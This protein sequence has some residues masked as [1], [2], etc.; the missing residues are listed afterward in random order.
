[1]RAQE[2]WF[3]V[4]RVGGEWW[5]FN[6]L[7]QAPRP[8]SQ[9]Y[10]AAFLDS[11]R[12]QGYSI[13]VVRGPLPQPMPCEDA[14]PGSAGTWFTPAQVR[15]VANTSKARRAGR[16]G[17]Q[18]APINGAAGSGVARAEAWLLAGCVCP[19]VWRG[20]AL[21]AQLLKGA[22]AAGAGARRER[23]RAGRAAGGLP[24][25]CGE[26]RHVQGLHGM[27][28]PRRCRLLAIPTEAVFK[29]FSSPALHLQA[30]LW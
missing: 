14:K 26:W 23:G 2:H 20:L 7:A 10:L 19:V 3:T 18:D 15:R 12:G 11:L 25:G 24:Q 6:S 22:S 5:D 17:P 8:L 4:R 1:M 13:F 30:R 21:G 29:S 9:F 27:P 16:N 28:T